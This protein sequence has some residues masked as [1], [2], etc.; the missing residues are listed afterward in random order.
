[1][2]TGEIGGSG[3]NVVTFI[4][5]E[6]VGQVFLSAGEARNPPKFD[7]RLQGQP[8][9]AISLMCW[10]MFAASFPDGICPGTPARAFQKCMPLN[11]MKKADLKLYVQQNERQIW[12]EISATIIALS[13]ISLSQSDCVI[14]EQIRP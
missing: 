2:Y 3:G 9:P 12:N 13:A 10:I 1:L 5:D 14:E 4:G 11:V 8:N 7:K 6:S